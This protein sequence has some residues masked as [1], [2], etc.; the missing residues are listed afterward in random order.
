MTGKTFSYKNG[1][2]SNFPTD[3]EIAGAGFQFLIIFADRELLN[4]GNIFGQLKE[5]FKSSA[6]IFCS[7]A[8]EIHSNEIM[9]EG[10]V[11]VAVS[12]SKTTFQIA[13]DNLDNYSNSYEL[14]N[15]L[16]SGLNKKGLKYIMTIADGHRVNGDELLAGIQDNVDDSVV[17]SGG[18]AGD[19][20]MFKKTLV[21]IDDN[22]KEGNVVLLALYGEHIKIGTGYHGGWDV[23]GP[24]RIITKSEGNVL[25]EIDG[26]NALDLYKKYLGNYADGL[27]S[28]A[29]F[30]PITIK[31]GE[32]DFFLVRTILSVDERNK[33]M[34]FAGN[35]PQGSTMRFMKSNF[36]RLI[37]AAYEAG[38]DAM[39]GLGGS[40]SELAILVSC[41]GRKLILAN[42]TEEEVEA[43]IE[44]L[45]ENT[46][47]TGFFSYGEI[48]PVDKIRKSHLHNQTLSVTVF[49][50]LP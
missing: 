17:I 10:A 41:I 35:L 47:I 14:G 9:S 3:E 25:Y 29:L 18:M 13:I 2:W 22:V 5:K 37:N 28:S 34:T 49:S 36:D 6:L 7:T 26:E 40:Q 21:G 44:S 45:S 15:H 38:K 4:S 27:P 33:T 24:E 39:N 43:A 30:F 48:A 19:G 42:R 12:F 46:L 32:D 50:E 16:A 11:C 8:G 1:I 20:V 23:Y 31:S